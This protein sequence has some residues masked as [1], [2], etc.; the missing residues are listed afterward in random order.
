MVAPFVLGWMLLCVWV[1]GCG[2]SGT[3]ND[4]LGELAQSLEEEAKKAS[5]YNL[6]QTIRVIY[7]LEEGPSKLRDFEDYA[8]FL[9][10]YD[11]EGVAPDVIAA[12]AAL[13]PVIREL[14]D[15]NASKEENESVW[16]AFQDFQGPAGLVMG[17]GASLVAGDYLGGAL[18]ILGA[19]RT[20]LTTAMERH[21][22]DEEVAERLQSATEAYTEYLELSSK[23]FTKYMKEWDAFCVVRDQAYLSV[24]HGD[25]AAAEIHAAQALERAP[26]D[27]ESMLLKVFCGLMK[28]GGL[29][30]LD[31]EVASSPTWEEES[32]MVEDYLQRYPEQSAPGLLLKGMIAERMGRP[33][34]A[35]TLYD[36]SAVLYPKQAAM[37][38]DMMNPY[39]GRAHFGVSVESDFV[40]EL[41]KATMEGF[42]AFSPNFHK[43]AMYMSDGRVEEAQEEVRMHFFRR[44]GQVVQDYLPTDLAFC[45]NE[46]PEAVNSLL[47]E[48]PFLDIAI[49]EGGLLD[50]DNAVYATIS[51]NSSRNLENVRLFLCIHFTGT[52]RN[53]YE[54]FEMPGAIRAIGPFE[55][56]SFEDPA[57]IDF[58]WRGEK[59]EA[60][61]DVV[62]VRGV[63]VTDDIVA[64]VDSDGFKLKR[65]QE[66][67]NEKLEASPQL[68]AYVEGVEQSFEEGYVYTTGTVRFPR[69]LVGLNPYVSL[70]EMNLPSAVYPREKRITSNY[71]E[72]VFKTT[73]GLDELSFIHLST[74]AGSVKIPLTPNPS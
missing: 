47:V 40:L 14:S 31:G 7:A 33:S 4:A 17:G 38:L 61:G 41:Y 50:A 30:G 9:A 55:S 52:Y 45:Q 65:A 56:Q 16:R 35:M 37:L 49:E 60:L 34:E 8:Q 13:V 5:T 26:Y 24:H 58:T 43:A 27:R 68:K 21:E 23:A 1:S 29:S 57:V 63:L 62:H 70:G 71:I 6:E 18:D 12:Q 22:R 42:G 53:T 72:Y 2:S 39:Q 69:D 32:R 54:V 25:Y 46:I 66:T 74:D 20:A 19:G 48:K 28:A 44:G 36:E 15:A 59:K 10:T 73:D 11:Y 67:I 64:W 3:A 51:N